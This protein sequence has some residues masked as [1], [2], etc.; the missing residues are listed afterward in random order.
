MILSANA[1]T[2]PVALDQ[3]APNVLSCSRLEELTHARSLRV[4]QLVREHDRVGNNQVAL[5]LLVALP[6]HTLS[7]QALH[8]TVRCHCV[9]VQLDLHAHARNTDGHTLVVTDSWPQIAL[10]A[11]MRWHECAH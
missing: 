8:E 11:H 4:R 2:S 7:S 6:W 5:R 1:I 9:S 3:A 10:Q